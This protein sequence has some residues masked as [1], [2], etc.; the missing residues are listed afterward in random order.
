MLRRE[1]VATAAVNHLVNK[2][3]ITFL[4]RL[5]AATKAGIGEVVAAYLEVDRE[6]DAPA[7]RNAVIAKGSPSEAENRA[8]LEI[9]ESLE[10]AVR[11]RL[12]GEKVSTPKR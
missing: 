3:G 12:G 11:K 7:K 2:A 10:A 6:T 9:E 8:L 1:I 4:S 5:T